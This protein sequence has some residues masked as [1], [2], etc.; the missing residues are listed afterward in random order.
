VLNASGAKIEGIG[1]AVLKIHGTDKK[2]LKIEEFRIIPDLLFIQQ[3]KSNL[4]KLL[5]RSIQPFRQI[6]RHNLWL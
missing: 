4:S 6:C 3:I 5:H 1:T 2:L